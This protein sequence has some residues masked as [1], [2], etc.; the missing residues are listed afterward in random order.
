MSN[1][2]TS[3]TYTG[4]GTCLLEHMLVIAKGSGGQRRHVP[5]DGRPRSTLDIDGDLDVRDEDGG[6]EEV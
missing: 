3:G 2:G 4:G 1:S 5:K 6:K